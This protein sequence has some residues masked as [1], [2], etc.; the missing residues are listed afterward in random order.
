VH[1]QFES[2]QGTELSVIVRLDALY[3]EDVLR[4]D[5]HAISF[6]FAARQVDDRRDHPWGVFA[7]VGCGQ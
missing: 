6:A 1:P 3:P 2:M 7:A 4:A 5:G